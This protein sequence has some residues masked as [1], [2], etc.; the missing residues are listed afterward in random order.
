MK[1]PQ[2]IWLAVILISAVFIYGQALAPA[3]RVNGETL[4][5]GDFFRRLDG[6]SRYRTLSSQ[7][8]SD[9]D[10]ERGILLAFAEEAL[11]KEELARRGRSEGE[12]EKFVADKVNAADIPNLDAATRRLYGWGFEDFKK[13]VLYPQARRLML[14]QEFQKDKRDAASWLDQSLQRAKISVYLP[15]W[16]WESGEFRQRY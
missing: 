15:R 14:V 13:F 5:W 8:V 9:L 3:L 2:K 4:S 16:K 1:S 11:I 12:A 10:M 7:K 6:F